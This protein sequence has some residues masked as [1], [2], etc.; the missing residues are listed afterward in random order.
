MRQVVHLITAAQMCRRLR[1]QRMG[2]RSSWANTSISTGDPEAAHYEGDK[3]NAE[4]M[5]LPVMRGMWFS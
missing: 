4:P 3:K 1:G 2:S 5:R